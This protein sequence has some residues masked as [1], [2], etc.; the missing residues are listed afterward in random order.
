MEEQRKLPF[1][2]EIPRDHFVEKFLAVTFLIGDL[3]SC[4]L[5]LIECGTS[6]NRERLMED[7][8]GSFLVGSCDGLNATGCTALGFLA[9]LVSDNTLCG[10]LIMLTSSCKFT[11]GAETCHKAHL[12][13]TG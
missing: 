9:N 10:V 7:G 1:L 3:I 4:S 11:S 2:V 6:E 5:A 8:H 12:S 13:S